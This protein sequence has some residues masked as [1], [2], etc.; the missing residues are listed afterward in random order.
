MGWEMIQIGGI[1]GQHDQELAGMYL[2]EAAERV[3]KKPFDLFVDLLVETRLGVSCLV[4]MGIEENVQ[5]ILQ[6]P[7]HMVGSDGILVGQRPH[8]R[9]WG[10]HVRFLAHYTRDL[11]LLTWEQ[12]I[13]RMTS[14]PARR[15]GTLDRGL[16]RP[17]FMADLVLFDPDTLRDT[18]TYENPRSYPEGVHLVVN[19]GIVIVDDGQPTG[20]IPGRVLRSP[21][22]RQPIRAETF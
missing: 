19:N 9:G 10:S 22:G 14:A 11:G 8:P 5:T 16:I 7:A 15:I 1:I 4:H 13:R 21:F 12:A 18:A 17:G 2:P 6:H 20:R 3:G